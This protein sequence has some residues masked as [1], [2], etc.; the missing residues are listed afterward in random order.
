[1]GAGSESVIVVV[2]GL[3]FVAVDN[4]AVN[5]S[6][7]SSVPS[8]KMGTPIALVFDPIPSKGVATFT[9]RLLT[10]K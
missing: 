10:A 7:F 3:P 5:V 9:G 2:I 8:D 6:S 4:V 1:M